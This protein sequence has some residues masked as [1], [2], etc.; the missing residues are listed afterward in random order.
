[1]TPGELLQ[2]WWSLPADKRM[3]EFWSPGQVAFQLGITDSR[4]RGCCSEGKIPHIK[5]AGR[6]YIH[7]P[8][9]LEEL[10][11]RQGR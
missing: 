11:A 10:V 3:D 6:I 1:M 9:M 2:R 8:S 4:V 5:I 7:V